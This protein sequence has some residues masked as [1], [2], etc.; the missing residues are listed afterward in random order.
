[1]V[2]VYTRIEWVN[3]KDGQTTPLGASNLNKMDA[4]IAE[5]DKRIVEL[6]TVKADK[7]TVNTMLADCD[8]DEETGIVKLT[9][10]NGEQIIFDLNIE[11]IPVAFALSEAG[12]LTMT[13]EDGTEWT[14]DIGAMIPVLTFNNSDTVNVIA[15]GSGENKTYRFEVKDGSI[16]ESKLRPDYLAEIKIESGNAATSAANAATS[17]AD[18][19][20][21]AKTAQECREQAGKTVTQTATDSNYNNW[22]PVLVGSQNNA[23][24]SFE[25]ETETGETYVSDKIVAQPSTGTLKAETFKGD[26]DGN[27]KTAHYT[28]EAPI[29]CSTWSR[30]CYVSAQAAVHGSC[31]ILNVS[32][33]RTGLVYHDTFLIKVHHP[34]RAMITKLS[35]NL[36]KNGIKYRVIANY[37]GNCYVE[38]YDTVSSASVTSKAKCSLVNI[39]AGHVTTFTEFTDGTTLPDKWSVAAE[40]TTN[41][42]SLQGNLSWEEITDKPDI[43]AVPDWALQEFKPTYTAA[44][45]GADAAGAADN[46]MTIVRNNYTPNHLTGVK[47]DL[48]GTTNIGYM[49]YDADTKSFG[50]EVGLPNLQR[51]LQDASEKI[52]N[53]MAKMDERIPEV[54]TMTGATTDA[55]GT[56]GLVPAPA[57]GAQNRFLRADGTWVAPPESGGGNAGALSACFAYALCADAGSVAAKTATIQ[58]DPNWELKVGSVV[59]V[60]Y[61]HA[62]GASQKN[63]TLNIN[64]T[65]AKQIFY[66]YNPIGNYVGHDNAIG[67]FNGEIV[68]YMY[69]GTYW[70]YVG[71]GEDRNS[72][73][74]VIT[75]A[76]DSADGTSGL[77]PRPKPGDNTKFLRGDGTWASPSETEY[78]VNMI[79]SKTSTDSIVVSDPGIYTIVVYKYGTTAPVDIY[80][81]V[82]TYDDTDTFAGKTKN[83]TAAMS[84]TH[85]TVAVSTNDAGLKITSAKGYEFTITYRAF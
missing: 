64:D 38:L 30:L 9:R 37:N 74:S 42:N 59:A 81:Y 5:M 26:L 15:T 75:G 83:V 79:G 41:A 18:A 62:N 57:K 23:N 49:Y 21:S 19:A 8:Y 65:G 13:T 45:V 24:A 72:T 47:T 51:A 63:I 77:V 71:H 78:S 34:S 56:G 44:E 28:W 27:A 29:T 11:K 82:Y 85:G 55:D 61:S 50:G 2:E 25:A 60:K 58:N 54:T 76:T 52:A 1:M 33:S 48:Y 46:I 69:D 67:R 20:A 80:Q 6:D 22:R 32:V 16:T 14:A 70:A 39:W 43:P 4:A 17:A 12:V 68:V 84:S 40:I 31:F 66:L 53:S 10:Q 7:M 73:Y 36:Y 35:G 3:K